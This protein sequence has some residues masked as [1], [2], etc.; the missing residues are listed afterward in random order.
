MYSKVTSLRAINLVL[1][2]LQKCVRAPRRALKKFKVT[3][4][5]T[6]SAM[7]ASSELPMDLFVCGC[8]RGIGNIWVWWVGSW[9]GRRAGS[10]SDPPR[11][12]PPAL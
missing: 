10:G 2:N 5:E 7:K 1:K 3:K 12:T 6:I 9:S 8:L 11:C 4:M